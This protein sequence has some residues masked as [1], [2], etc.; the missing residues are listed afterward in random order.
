MARAY[1]EAYRNDYTL[2][3]WINAREETSKQVAIADIGLRLGWELN[4]SPRLAHREVLDRLGE[5]AGNILLVFDD[6][7]NEETFRE[8]QPP[9][10]SIRIIITTNAQDWGAAAQPIPITEWTREIGARYLVSRVPRLSHQ[11]DAAAVLSST[12]YHLPL[13][14]EHAA[15]YCEE[16]KV[17]FIAYNESFKCLGL[18]ILRDPDFVAL[19]YQRTR[20][21]RH[22]RTVAGTL[23]L[24]LRQASRADGAE[25]L[26]NYL[27]LLAVDPVPVSFFEEAEM[28]SR[29]GAVSASS[30]RANKAIK[31][32]RQ[33]SLVYDERQPDPRNGQGVRTIRLHGLVRKIVA[34]RL[35]DHEKR[36]KVAQL[37]EAII[38]VLPKEAYSDQRNWLDIRFYDPHAR[39]L[40]YDE[41]SFPTTHQSSFIKLLNF[42]AEYRHGATGAYDEALRMFERA[43]SVRGKLAI[44]EC[45]S[46]MQMAI[47]AS[48]HGLGWLL[49]TAARYDEATHHFISALRLR[50]SVLGEDHE[51]TAETLH[52]LGWLC[53]RRGHYGWAEAFLEKV[54]PV[55]DS[56]PDQVSVTKAAPLV[57][58]GWLYLTWGDYEKAEHYSSRAA[59]I[60]NMYGARNTVV[61]ASVYTLATVQSHRGNYAAAEHNFTRALELR[62][63]MYA[64]PNE[65]VANTLAGLGTLRIRQGR[66]DDAATCFAEALGTFEALGLSRHPR[67]AGALAGRAELMLMSGLPKEAEIVA[68]E[69]LAI[70]ESI[71]SSGHVEQAHSQWILARAI[72]AQ[73][74]LSPE[75]KAKAVDLLHQAVNT[76]KRRVLPSHVWRQGAEKTLAALGA[77]PAK[78]DAGT[79]AVRRKRPTGT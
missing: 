17:D 32:L 36:E 12:L 24:A 57:T 40:V 23:E 64:E 35:D 74:V 14:L 72:I 56:M 28:L 77:S 15:T 45:D 59:Q 27:S 1:V 55:F 63:S 69:S 61:A 46:G 8:Y 18:E 67:Y 21:E 25:A 47:A 30:S 62:R 33:Y 75:R 4:P 53:V 39:S 58:M 3:A 6:E 78:S 52:R 7:K 49:T 38:R 70:R 42:L 44:Q 22:E 79:K 10:E 20:E 16:C 31:A 9:H 71:K 50:R 68:G 43:L 66:W 65:D 13:A 60:D 19:D 5:V 34:A 11:T 76:L 41:N 54:I 2:I 51:D 48:H 26:L 29:L 73:D 37:I